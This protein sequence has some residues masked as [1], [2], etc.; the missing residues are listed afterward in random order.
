[1]S[2]VRPRMGVAL[3]KSRAMRTGVRSGGAN[4]CSCEQVFGR[5]GM[6]TCVRANVCSVGAVRGANIC[7]VVHAFVKALTITVRIIKHKII[8]A[9]TIFGT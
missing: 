4:R 5:V 9:L 1:M 7:S 8:K 6:R 3:G 2:Q